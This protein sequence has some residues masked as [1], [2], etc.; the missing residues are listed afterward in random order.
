MFLLARPLVR[1]VEEKAAGEAQLRYELTR[2]KDNAEN[3]R[4]GD[5]DERERLDVTFSDL[6]QR[7]FGVIVW[8]GRMMWLHGANLVLAPLF[9]FCSGRQN[10]SQMRSP[11]VR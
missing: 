10:I 6:V 1:R 2:V 4:G 11:S 3:Y 8:Q 7:W 5:D 9:R